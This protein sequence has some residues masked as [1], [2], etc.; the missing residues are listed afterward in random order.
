MKRVIGTTG[1]HKGR[2]D[3]PIALALLLLALSRPT[4]AQ[5]F[6]LTVILAFDAPR[7]NE[8]LIYNWP[9]LQKCHEVIQG[10]WSADSDGAALAA[11]G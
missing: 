2:S 10:D 6:T 8:V 11:G 5:G 7:R 1:S 9:S 4:H 3:Y